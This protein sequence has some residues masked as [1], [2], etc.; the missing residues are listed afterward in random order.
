MKELAVCERYIYGRLKPVAEAYG[1]HK[2]QIAPFDLADGT[3]A[4][5]DIPTP[6]IYFRHVATGDRNAVGPG[7]RLMSWADYEIGLFH[8]GNSFGAKLKV[9]GIIDPTKTVLEIMD[10][11]DDIFQ[12]YTPPIVEPSLGGVVYSVQRQ[13]AVRIPERFGGRLYRRD[14]GVY[15][16]HV[17]AD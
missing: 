10:E 13:F 9:T 2:P 17:E 1:W 6:V 12:N 8:T 4:N 15:R 14:G 11:I 16:F 5:S 7:E 3:E